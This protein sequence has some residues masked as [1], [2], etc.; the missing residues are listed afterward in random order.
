MNLQLQVRELKKTVFGEVSST[1]P[2]MELGSEFQYSHSVGLAQWFTFPWTVV[3][4]HFPWQMRMPSY[5]KTT[6]RPFGHHSLQHT[7]VKVCDKARLDIAD[8]GLLW[9]IWCRRCWHHQWP[10]PSDIAWFSNR[11]WRCG[12][13]R[14]RL[15]WLQNRCFVLSVEN[16][17]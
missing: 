8:S 9:L 1:T 12:D 6:N 7:D 5:S 11:W 16:I 3:L 2:A 14:G 13:H 4:A 10:L 15:T 17:W